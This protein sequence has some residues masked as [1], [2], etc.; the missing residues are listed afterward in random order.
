MINL[1]TD[2]TG[3][4]R[5][6]GRNLAQDSVALSGGLLVSL[7]NFIFIFLRKS[8]CAWSRDLS[9]LSFFSIKCFGDLA[10][11]KYPKNSMYIPTLFKVSATKEIEAKTIPYFAPDSFFA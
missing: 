2:P 11:G 4:G 7:M 9:S 6:R 5:V 10:I 8:A 1:D 3:F